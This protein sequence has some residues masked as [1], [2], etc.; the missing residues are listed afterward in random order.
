MGGLFWKKRKKRGAQGKIALLLPLSRDQN[1]V[2][3]EGGVGGLVRRP[4]GSAAAVGRGKWR[5]GRGGSFPHLIWADAVRGGLATAASG[6]DLGG[7]AAR[8]GGGR[9]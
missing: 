4:W 2:G 5:G 7:G 3:G 9:G 8:L 1:R 6:G